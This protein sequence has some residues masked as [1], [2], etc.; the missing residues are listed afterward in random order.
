MLEYIDLNYK[1]CS[2]DLVTCYYL[3]PNNIPLKKA[4]EHVAGE[5]SIGTWTTISTMNPKI[6]KKLKP[7]VFHINKNGYIKIAYPEELF[8]AGNMPEIW[9][10]I[11]GNVFGMK[12]VKNL[13][14]MDI[15]FPKS[16]INSFKGPKYGIKGIR[17]LLKV[18]ERPFVGTIVNQTLV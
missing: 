13:R 5:S 14:L 12:A 16:I 4:C 18:K 17:N 1:P 11:A 9:S 15:D 7:K 2:T 3:E 8:E 10:S 6:A